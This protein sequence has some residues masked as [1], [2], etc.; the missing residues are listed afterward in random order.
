[1]GKAVL[2]MEKNTFLSSE[3][4]F[5]TSKAS[6]P[7]LLRKLYVNLQIIRVYTVHNEKYSEKTDV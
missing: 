5:D 3:E 6:A 1:M 7:L 4:H 2:A